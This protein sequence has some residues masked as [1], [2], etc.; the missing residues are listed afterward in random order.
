MPEWDEKHKSQQYAA[1]KRSHFSFVGH[2]QLKVKRQ[3]KIFHVNGK[4]KRTE[5]SRHIS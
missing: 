5:L 3:K 2:T 4:Q 1:Y